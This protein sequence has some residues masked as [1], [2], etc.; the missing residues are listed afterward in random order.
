MVALADASL[1]RSDQNLGGELRFGMLETVRE[2]ARELLAASEGEAETRKRHAAFFLDLAEGAEP[3]LLGPDQTVWMDLLEEEHHNLR[4]ALVWARESTETE[5]GLRLSASLCIFWW[6]RGHLGEGR[7]WTE[8]FL[9]DASREGRRWAL[10]LPRARAFVGAGL[11]AD[12]QGYHDRAATLYEEGL[13]LYRELGDERGAAFAL[14]NLGQAIRARGDHDRA[15]ALSEEGLAISRKKGEHLS[16]AVALNTLGHVAR[17][18]GVHGRAEALYEES[19]AAFRAS[20]DERGAAY[21]LGN[22]GTTAL[23]RGANRRALALQEESLRIYKKRKDKAGE[24]FAL[25][26][27]RDATRAQGHHDRAIALYEESLAMHRKLG[28]QKGAVRA[29]ERLAAV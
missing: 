17:R 21:T 3:H 9:K 8:Y 6:I 4:G 28:N 20:G 15:K 26:N 1:L 2:Y 13:K 12:G 22:V 7:E 25:I 18:H 19:L 27:L 23:E 24:A 16:A 10:D 11:L 5:M 29:L 14:T